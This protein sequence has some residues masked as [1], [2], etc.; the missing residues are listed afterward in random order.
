MMRGMY[1]YMA[2]AALFEEC[3]SGRRFQVAQ[4]ADNVALERAYLEA[5]A[6]P[7]DP[8]LVSFQGRIAERPAMEG[9]G[10]VLTVVPERFIGI[11]P[12]E[13][14]G[15]RGSTSELKDNRWKLV[16]LGD[17]PVV[18]GQNQREAHIVLRSKD[19]RITGTGGCNSFSGSYEI[20]GDTIEFG[21]LA[22]T[23]MACPEGEDVDLALVAALEK[24]ATFQKTPHHLELFDTDGKSLARFEARELQ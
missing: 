5:R 10:T 12:G 4:E 23:M 16:R 8:I 3:S 11:R 24:A 2:D 15:A 13:T 9:G 18:T 1:R 14:C 19:R 20:E 7:G 17:E 21:A 6:E 22:T